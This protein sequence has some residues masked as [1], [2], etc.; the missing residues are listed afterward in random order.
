[1]KAYSS[2]AL[3]GGYTDM[4]SGITPSAE[5]LTTKSE[6]TVTLSGLPKVNG[7]VFD[8]ATGWISES[9]ERISVVSSTED[10]LVLKA[11]RPAYISIRAYYVLSTDEQIRIPVEFRMAANVTEPLEGKGTASMPYLIKDAYDL[12]AVAEYADQNAYFVLAEDIVLT[13]ADYEFGGSFYN[14]GNGIVTIGNTEVAFNGNFSGLYGG[15]IHSITG[16]RMNGK[17]FGGLFGATD[18]AV[19]T[20]L[21]INGADITASADAGVLIGRANDTTIKN[22]TVN[23]AK[24][25]TTQSG[26]VAGGLVGIAQSTI[27]EDVT[28]NNVEVSTT[29]DSTSATLEIAGGAAGVYDGLIKNSELNNVT[30]VSGTVAG[31]VIGAVK[32]EPANIVNVDA[33]VNVKADFA[34]GFAGRISAPKALSV[35]GSVVRGEVDG[36]KVAS[37]VIAQISSENAGDAFDK[38]NR[39]LVTETVITADIKGGDVKALVIGEVSEAVAVD[40]ENVKNDVF[41]NVYYSSYQ[42]DLGAFGAEQFNA[43]RNSEYAVTDLSSLAYK[44]GESV[45]ETVELTTEFATLPENSI[46]LN[47]AT[48]T[49]KSFT[50]G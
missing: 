3:D 12:E 47:N 14:V 38:L 39:N 36:A 43:Y 5:A 41:L 45:Y 4:N 42:N 31:G 29:L 15:K 17:T 21:V 1:M 23:N 9:E 22:V 13:D 44:V 19:I 18:G 32:A 8:S 10:S 27:I 24:V 26:S 2:E 46:V 20:D 16:L 37:G 40:S 7:F 11:N 50:A 28:L 48:G 25:V 30:V 33:D 34:G 49:Y 35:N 6:T